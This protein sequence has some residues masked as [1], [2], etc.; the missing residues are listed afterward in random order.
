MHRGAE[1]LRGKAMALGWDPEP[2][3][4]GSKPTGDAAAYPRLKVMV[5]R[6]RAAHVTLADAVREAGEEGLQRQ[7]PW[8]ASGNMV[9]GLELALRMLFHNGTHCG[10]IV[11]LRRALGLPSVIQGAP[12]PRR[13]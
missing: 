3:A 7:V 6:Y 9:S 2:F 1:K 11:D 8:G 10:Q 4:F 5:E 13:A 12:P